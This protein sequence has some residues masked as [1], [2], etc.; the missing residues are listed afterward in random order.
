MRGFGVAWRLATLWTVSL[1]SASFLCLPWH[2]LCSLSVDFSIMVLS[3][4][5]WPFTQGPSFTIPVEVIV[6]VCDKVLCYLVPSAS[7]A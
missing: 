2:T 5:A 3:S 1:R 7:F 4:G 6:I